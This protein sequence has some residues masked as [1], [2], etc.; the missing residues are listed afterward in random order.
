M[1]PTDRK[2]KNKTIYLN[3]LLNIFVSLVTFYKHK[4]SYIINCSHY[5]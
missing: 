2:C 5:L 1:Q 4:G 3:K